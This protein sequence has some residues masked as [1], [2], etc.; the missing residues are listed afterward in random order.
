MTWRWKVSNYR[1]DEKA[2]LGI[3]P[4][5]GLATYIKLGVP[6]QKPSKPSSSLQG[7]EIAINQIRDILIITVY[8]P[9][10]TPLMDLKKS[11][12]TI[13]THQPSMEQTIVIGDFNVDYLESS[14]QRVQLESFFASYGLMQRVNKATTDMRTCL[15]H[16]YTNIEDA[17]QAVVG[18]S[19]TYFSYHKAVWIALNH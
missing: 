10:T 8:K 13:F 5:Y 11:L 7:V 18:V 1:F 17:E 9:P 16:I 15:D 6:H 2:P 19:E 3:R 4:Y 14:N 12:M